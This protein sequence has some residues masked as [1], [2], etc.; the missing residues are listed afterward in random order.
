MQQKFSAIFK[1]K[2]RIGR[3]KSSQNLTHCVSSFYIPYYFHLEKACRGL[4]KSLIF[5]SNAYLRYIQK[6]TLNTLIK[7]NGQSC[8]ISWSAK[9][10]FKENS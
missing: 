8:C 5:L 9:F 2:K 6:K 4:R 3:A 10:N 1:H 7:V